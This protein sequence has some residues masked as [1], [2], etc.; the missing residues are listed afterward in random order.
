M[1]IFE[2]VQIHVLPLVTNDGNIITIANKKFSFITHKIHKYMVS[3]QGEK[4]HEKRRIGK[5]YH[6]FQDKRY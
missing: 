1:T 2:I 6:I 5:K 3:V 4:D